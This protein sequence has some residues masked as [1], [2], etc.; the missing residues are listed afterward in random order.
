MFLP[1]LPASA[2][3]MG[4]SAENAAR[5]MTDVNITL[6]LIMVFAFGKTGSICT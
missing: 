4:A 2:D 5:A 6:F 3:S 1:R